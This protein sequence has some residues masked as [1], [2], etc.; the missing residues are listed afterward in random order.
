MVGSIKQLVNCIQHS[1]EAFDKLLKSQKPQ[2]FPLELLEIIQIT[3]L[4]ILAKSILVRLKLHSDFKT[5]LDAV[6]KLF[7]APNHQIFSLALLYIFQIIFLPSLMKSILVGL[8]S[9]KT[10]S[11]ETL[12]Q[13]T[14]SWRLPTTKY[15]H[16]HY[17]TSSNLSLY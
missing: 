7:E 11:R 17:S 10:S 8:K 4:L 15:S 5:I 13:L 3:A 14:S 6:D 16:Q 1:L 2:T 9:C 12:I